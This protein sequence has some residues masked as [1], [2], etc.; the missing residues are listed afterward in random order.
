MPRCIIAD[1]LKRG[2]E[3]FVV[4]YEGQ[5]PRDLV[6]GLPHMWTHFGA[7]G[8]VIETL[9]SHGISDLVM[10]GG[11][12]RPSLLEL[13]PDLKA[14]KILGKIGLNAFGDDGLLKILKAELEHEGFTLHGVSAFSEQL[15]TS[16]GLLGKV[17]PISEDEKTIELGVKISQAV[18]ALDIG[19]S[20]IVQQ[21][22]VIG[23]EAVEGTDALIERCG[24]LLKT[25]RGGILVKTCKPQQDR[26]LDLPAIGVETIERAYKYGLCG[27][28]VHAGYSI[29]LDAKSVAEVADAYNIFVTGID[30]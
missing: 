30:V 16:E 4:A 20:V 23:I 6:D 8:Y 13:R 7:V 14:I 25:G 26:D 28:V 29:I 21:G 10:A 18:G 17:K 2:I 12:K 3:V 9:K 22:V 11:M 5:T 15:I 1:C 27:V 19:Q 24:G